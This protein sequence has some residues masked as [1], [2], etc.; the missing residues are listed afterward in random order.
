MTSIICFNVHVLGILST[1]RNCVF[2][3]ILNETEVLRLNRVT[4]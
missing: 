2:R 4:S 1:V 3:M